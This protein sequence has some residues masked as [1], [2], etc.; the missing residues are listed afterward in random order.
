[1][2]SHENIDEEDNTLPE[3]ALD[4][5]E[6]EEAIELVLDVDEFFSDLGTAKNGVTPHKHPPTIYDVMRDGQ[7]FSSYITQA[8]I[9]QQSFIAH[10]LKLSVR[11][12]LS[13][14]IV[15]KATTTVRHTDKYF[16]KF[17]TGYSYLSSSLIGIG[18]FPLR[19]MLDLCI[20]WGSN[21][22]LI[23]RYLK[24]WDE[25]D[26]AVVALYRDKLS[27]TKLRPSNP[28]TCAE[29]LSLK[30]FVKV[31]NDAEEA[32]QFLGAESKPSMNIVDIVLESILNNLSLIIDTSPPSSVASSMAKRLQN[33]IIDRRKKR[34]YDYEMSTLLL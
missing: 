29:V 27:Y 26:E 2:M 20:R 7:G 4:S 13:A 19:L 34:L 5:L 1:M 22:R 23:Q 17:P 33:D 21:L 9:H 10:S 28:F 25:V 3:N 6:E 11:A 12:A 32:T 8:T 31:L 24:I 14:T 15:R 18:K 16:R 30:D